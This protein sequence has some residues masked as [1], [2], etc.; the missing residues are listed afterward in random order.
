MKKNN[1]TSKLELNLKNKL[2]KCYILSITFYGAENWSLWNVNQKRLESFEMRWLRRMEISW[3]Y[4]VRNWMVLHRVREKRNILHTVKRRKANS[5]VHILSRNYLLKHTMEGN[6]ENEEED[7]RSYWINVKKRENTRCWKWK[8][9]IAICGTRA[10]E[11]AMD[12]S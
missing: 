9:K 1:F 5:I 2:V 10:L 4:R 8:L 3:T 7:M 11:G 6:R 12:L